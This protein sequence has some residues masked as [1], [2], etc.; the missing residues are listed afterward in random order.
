MKIFFKKTDL[1]EIWI[2]ILHFSIWLWGGETFSAVSNNCSEYYLGPSYFD[3]YETIARSCPS[4]TNRLV[5]GRCLPMNEKAV[6]NTGS[7][8]DY[9]NLQYFPSITR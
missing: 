8:G 7:Y 1:G 6:S 5:H 9:Y 4:T 3:P 2:P